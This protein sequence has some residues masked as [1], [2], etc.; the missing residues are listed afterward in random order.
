M[1]EPEGFA[2]PESRHLPSGGERDIPEVEQ[3]VMDEE[4]TNLRQTESRKTRLCVLIG[5][6]ILQL[7]IW[8]TFDL[9]SQTPRYS[10][11]HL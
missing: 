9:M 2:P 5:S 4:Q 7:P 10:R 11:T 8:G 6:G 1:R 3:M